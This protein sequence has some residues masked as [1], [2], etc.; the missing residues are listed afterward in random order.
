MKKTQINSTKNESDDSLS[1][2]QMFGFLVPFPTQWRQTI[3]EQENYQTEKD[4]PSQAGLKLNEESTS[5]ECMKLSWSQP[6]SSETSGS[7]QEHGKDSLE[8]G[9]G[10]I[11]FL[12]EPLFSLWLNGDV[13]LSDGQMFQKASGIS[14]PLGME[15]GMI[16]MIH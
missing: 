12:P 7:S 13:D 1:K 10:G 8:H 6:T 16:V 9:E 15:V 3:G 4:S 14:S 11:L 2:G 5:M